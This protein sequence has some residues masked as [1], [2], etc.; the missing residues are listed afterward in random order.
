MSFTYLGNTNGLYRYYYL[1]F[2]SP[3]YRRPRESTFTIIITT[4]VSVTPALNWL[5]LSEGRTG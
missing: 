3:P 4:H 2:C 1:I 5:D